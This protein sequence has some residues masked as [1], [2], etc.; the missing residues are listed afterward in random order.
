M[1]VLLLSM[2]DS[3]T[4]LT[5]AI[6]CRTAPSPRWPN[7]DP[8]HRVSIADLILVHSRVRIG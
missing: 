3:S 2:P 6:R 4:M 1:N 8:H 7:L 5:V